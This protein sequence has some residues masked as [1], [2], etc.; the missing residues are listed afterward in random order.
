MDLDTIKRPFWALSPA[1]SIN[2]L[3]T[4][5]RGLSN[6]EVQQRLKFFGGNIFKKTKRITKLRIFLSQFKSPLIFIL[7]IAAVVTLFLEDWISAG[8]VI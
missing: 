4:T 1:D 7:I 8:V 5:H 2:I 3:E 6:E